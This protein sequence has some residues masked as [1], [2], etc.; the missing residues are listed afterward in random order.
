[1]SPPEVIGRAGRLLPVATHGLGNDS[2]RQDTGPM[3][4][5][6]G[7]LVCNPPDIVPA[8]RI[9]GTATARRLL[10]RAGQITC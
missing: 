1:M 6:G 4:G 10:P 3:S 7:G 2:G 5:S 8:M 9:D